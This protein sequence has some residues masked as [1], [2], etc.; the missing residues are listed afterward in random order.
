LRCEC[1]RVGTMSHE[2]TS[3]DASNAGGKISKQS[4]DLWRNHGRYTT[5]RGPHLC[6]WNSKHENDQ[7]CQTAREL[8]RW[9]RAC[10]PTRCQVGAQDRANVR[11]ADLHLGGGE[12]RSKKAVTASIVTRIDLT[13]TARFH[14]MLCRSE[15]VS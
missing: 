10:A 13:R 7:A 12:G 6:C 4:T 8:R 15:F 3:F 2:E 1:Y 11:Y 14:L 9:S 5:I